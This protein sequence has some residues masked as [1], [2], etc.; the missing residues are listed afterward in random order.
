[1]PQGYKKNLEQRATLYEMVICKITSSPSIA[2]KVEELLQDML[3]DRLC[4]PSDDD[5]ELWRKESA[6]SSLLNQF[7]CYNPVEIKAP[8]IKP[9]EIVPTLQ[10]STPEAPTDDFDETSGTLAV[11][12]HSV[13]RYL[14]PTSGLHFLGESHVLQKGLLLIS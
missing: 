2:A 4:I 6:V 11:D 13:I 12:E 8:P 9:T 10:E 14:G 7:A 3:N 5:L 1:L